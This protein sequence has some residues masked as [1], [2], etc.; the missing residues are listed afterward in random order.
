MYLNE[1]ANGGGTVFPDIGVSVSAHRGNALT[2]FSY[3]RLPAGTP[4]TLHAGKRGVLGRKMANQ[5]L[6]QG[7]TFT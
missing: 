2:R 1:P 5:Q 6:A 7:G 4:K 3:E